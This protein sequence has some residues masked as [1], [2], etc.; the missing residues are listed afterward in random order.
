MGLRGRLRSTEGTQR[1]EHAVRD[2]P[3]VGD[4]SAAGAS[5]SAPEVACHARHIIEN[6]PQPCFSTFNF[7]KYIFRDVKFGEL[8]R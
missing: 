8:C 5:C 2:L 1:V 7:Q 4:G 6:R 3:E